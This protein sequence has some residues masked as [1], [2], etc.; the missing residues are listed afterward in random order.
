MVL[1][2]H[3]KVPLASSFQFKKL[4]F[5]SSLNIFAGQV[6]LLKEGVKGVLLHL[7]KKKKKNPLFSLLCRLNNK[8]FSCLLLWFKTQL[9]AGLVFESWSDDNNW[10]HVHP[11]GRV[12]DIST[13]QPTYT[14]D[15]WSLVCG[16]KFFRATLDPQ[17]ELFCCNFFFY[18]EGH[19]FPSTAFHVYI[20][21]KMD[22]DSPLFA[23]N[24]KKKSFKI[25]WSWNS[26][27]HM[28]YV[29][30]SN[31]L[32]IHICVPLD[33]MVTMKVRADEPHHPPSRPKK[34]KN[35]TAPRKDYGEIGIR[36]P[37]S[38]IGLPYRNCPT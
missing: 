9:A 1:G 25:F 17:F 32:I 15:W 21:E 27:R 38:M 22:F 13:H 28:L 8:H 29:R 11:I 23:T 24:P 36:D 35:K 19:F 4:L 5:Y 26:I 2:D 30:V 3:A 7:L 12:L 10:I 6:P 37:F 20:N 14:I 16:H 33:L 18:F 31:I 34:R